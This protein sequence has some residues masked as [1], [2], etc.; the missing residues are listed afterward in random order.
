VH[1]GERATEHGWAYRAFYPAA[2]WMRRLASDIAG[3]EVDVPWLPDDSIKDPELAARLAHAHRMLEAGSDMLAA[4]SALTAAFALLITRHARARPQP[5]ALRSDGA[6]VAAMQA[7]L[8][9]DLTAPLTLTQLAEAVGLSSFHAAR[10]FSAGVGMPPHAWRNQLRLS[11]ALGLLR[12]GMTVAD[13][14]AASGFT[15]QSHFTRHFKRAYGAAPGRW[16][17]A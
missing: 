12:Q 17:A 3:R 11:R 4:E 10:L 13:V 7:R 2:E 8:A 9:E 1:T 15:D 5:R 6:R 14:A 16:Q